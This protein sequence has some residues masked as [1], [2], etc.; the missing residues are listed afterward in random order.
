LEM[1]DKKY[2]FDF[3]VFSFDEETGF[4]LARGKD[5][6]GSSAIVG[7]EEDGNIKFQKIYRRRHPEIKRQILYTT[8]TDDHANLRF[9]DYYG[10]ISTKN[11]GIEAEGVYTTR[12]MH[13][14]DGSWRMHSMDDV[15]RIP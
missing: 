7:I 11:G 14:N 15:I 9:I 5:H 2:P 10:S 6:F 3:W 8:F 12:G 4:F 1:M 13:K